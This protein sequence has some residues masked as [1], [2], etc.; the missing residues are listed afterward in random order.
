MFNYPFDNWSFLPVLDSVQVKQDYGNEIS[1][2][3]EPTHPLGRLLTHHVNRAEFVCTITPK[4]SIENSWVT[5]AENKFGEAV[6]GAIAPQ[7]NKGAVLTFPQI[8]DK[9]R[10]LTELLKNVLPE[11]APHLFPHVEG[12]RWIQRP[13]Y[14]IPAIQ[15]L[16]D[17]IREVEEEAK[18]KVRRLEEAV[19]RVGCQSCWLADEPIASSTRR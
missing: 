1:V 13:E 3:A 9:P 19:Q 5:L 10:F 2:V 4:T 12:V 18:R 8:E 7:G 14:E 16:K 15:A 11:V 17:Q 6:A